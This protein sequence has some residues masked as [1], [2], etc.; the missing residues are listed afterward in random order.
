M[1]QELTSYF[2][3]ARQRNVLFGNVSGSI[4][5]AGIFFLQLPFA[6]IMLT[7]NRDAFEET[8]IPRSIFE[9][10][11]EKRKTRFVPTEIIVCLLGFNDATT[12]LVM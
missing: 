5:P 4:I 8:K 10:S 6:F 11:G 1:C 2:Q 3:F 9:I 12:A 7:S